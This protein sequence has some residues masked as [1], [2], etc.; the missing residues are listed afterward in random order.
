MEELTIKTK[1]ISDA[2]EGHVP[3][4]HCY[5]NGF[6]PGTQNNTY[7]QC[8]YDSDENCFYQSIYI[9][10]ENTIYDSRNMNCSASTRPSL[11]TVSDQQSNVF[12]TFI[13]IN[14]TKQIIL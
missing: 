11:S 2:T 4:P 7:Y 6:F 3:M 10:P 13:Y 14:I 12:A 1:I 9:C 5:S 8:E